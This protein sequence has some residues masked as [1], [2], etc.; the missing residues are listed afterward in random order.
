MVDI[1]KY[2]RKHISHGGRI[3]SYY[4]HYKFTREHGL[5]DAKKGY[6]SISKI[7][8]AMKFSYCPYNKKIIK[9]GLHP[10]KKLLEISPAK[11]SGGDCNIR[12]NCSFLSENN[13]Q[14]LFLHN[15]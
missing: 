10:I 2:T 11:I 12:K 1:T 6:T 13:F 7:L 4:G 8:N 9:F 14:C 3:H 15:F 5:Y